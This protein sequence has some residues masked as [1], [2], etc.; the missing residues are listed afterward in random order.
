MKPDMR[1][2][3]NWPHRVIHQDGIRF[4]IY[5]SKAG[6]GDHTPEF[7]V[8]LGMF[9]WAVLDFGWYNLHHQDDR[10]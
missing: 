1:W 8:Y 5:R 10:G 6:T 7:H 4:D 3:W 2:E 9:G